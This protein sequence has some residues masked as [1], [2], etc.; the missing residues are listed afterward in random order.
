[1]LQS[2]QKN[3]IRILVLPNQWIFQPHRTHDC[4]WFWNDMSMRWDKLFHKWINSN[5]SSCESIPL[6]SN[7]FVLTHFHHTCRCVFILKQQDK[8]FTTE[9]IKLYRPALF[10]PLKQF[11]LWNIPDAGN[12]MKCL[13]TTVDKHIGWIEHTSVCLCC[14][15]ILCSIPL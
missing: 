9:Y 12:I 5:N 2:Q 6:I 11:S 8:S 3:L 10:Y 1:M 15:D 13:S 14:E 4:L 7:R